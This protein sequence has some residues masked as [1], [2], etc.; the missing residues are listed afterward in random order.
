MR[1]ARSSALAAL[2]LVAAGLAYGA[3]GASGT[4]DSTRQELKQLQSDQKNKT[5]QSNDK[6][7]L[8]APTLDLRSDDGS[9]EAWLASKLKE[10]RKLKEQKKSETSGNWLVEGVEKL[11]KEESVAKSAGG[12]SGKGAAS[13]ETAPHPVDQSDSQYLLKLF[14]E[15]KKPADNKSTAAKSSPAGAPD[16]FAPFMQSWLGSSPVRGQ[17]FDQFARKSEGGGEGAPVVTSNYRGPSNSTAVVVAPEPVV[18]EK[19]NP[20][21][22]ELNAPILTREVVND[23][24]QLQPMGAP[25]IAP[26][27]AR[28]GGP[29]LLPAEP[30]PD[31]RERGKAPLPGLADDKKYFPQLKRF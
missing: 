24:S 13:S 3:E 7:R 27:A 8:D 4:L 6:I 20:Y 29:V 15:Q 14:D 31:A 22:T 11:E 12:P 23:T 18:A 10:E 16:A 17:F 1:I 25:L 9:P 21:L 5:G 26:E 2:L 30:A 28:G 19:S